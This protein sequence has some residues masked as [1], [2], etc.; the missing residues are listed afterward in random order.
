[1]RL[2]LQ[3]LEAPSSSAR[4]PLL[5]FSHL[6]WR[7]VMQRPQHLLS[8]AARTFDVMVLEEPVFGDGA[9]ELRIE[10]VDGLRLVV[11][12]LPHGLS[13]PERDDLLVE[14]VARLVQGL[15][16][17][18]F[19]YYTPAA[20]A[21]S[22]RLPRALTVYD[23]MDELS[24]FR[25][26]SPRLMGLERELL[27]TA[28]LVFTGGWSLY[29]SKRSLHRSVHCF[30]S[31]VDVAHFGRARGG[32]LL[33]PLDQAALPRP[34][35][36]FFGV[37]DE[38]MDLALVA[39]LAELRP[40]W[41]IVMLGPVVKIDAADLPQASNV[42][43][44]GLKRYEDLPAY[45]AFWDLAI[46]PFAL[47]EATRFISPTKTPEFLAG[48]LRVISTP[49]ADVVRAYGGTEAL[50]AIATGPT[51]AA[52]LAD[53]ILLENKVAWLE[54]VDARLAQGSWD[55]TWKAMLALIEAALHERRESPDG[56]LAQDLSSVGG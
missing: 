11:P 37:I 30:P 18:I 34:R 5:C 39:I 17:V 49:V 16:P 45:L 55:T 42:H 24:A 32:D 44:L 56:V 36:G 20:V 13:D 19:W 6:R 25:G 14:L 8:R 35:I 28:D 41:Q 29:E 1:M 9:A 27:A 48:G 26:A 43:W 52:D 15:P 51:E 54:R 47:N 46:M 31:S 33:D 10:P 7:F 22:R 38:R 23:N 4:I 53:A 3:N 21:F 12:H 40:Y 50:V 2:R